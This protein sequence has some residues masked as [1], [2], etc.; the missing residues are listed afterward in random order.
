LLDGR[1]DTHAVNDLPEQRVVSIEIRSVA[2]GDVELIV[3]AVRPG[4]GHAQHPGAHVTQGRIDLVGYRVA[5]F[6]RLFGGGRSTLDDMARNNAMKRRPIEERNPGGE[7]IVRDRSF[8]EPDKACHRHRRPVDRE[9]QHYD[10]LG[11]ENVCIQP[12]VTRVLVTCHRG[13]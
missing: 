4:V 11:C 10:A 3:R 5:G 8:G 6:T 2:E 13:R 1:H 7:G 9:L 12:I